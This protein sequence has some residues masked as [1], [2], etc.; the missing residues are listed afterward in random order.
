MTTSE[1]V[2]VQVVLREVKQD[3]K[4]LKI[5]ETLKKDPEGKANFQW[6]D[7]KLWYKGK[8]VLSRNSSLIP[9]LLHTYHDLVLGGHSRFLRTYKM[10]NGELHWLGMKADVKKYVELC[11]F[12]QRIK[13]KH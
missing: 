11:E 13:Q 7:D 10:M 4:L 6:K 8:L 1:L 5:I 2:D 3:E 9:S 12:C